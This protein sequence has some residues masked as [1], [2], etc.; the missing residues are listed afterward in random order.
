MKYRV[1]SALVTIACMVLP[2]FALAE[3]GARDLYNRAMAEERVIRD[4]ANKPT[5][6]QMRRVVTLYESVVRKHPA[7]GYCDNA[8][9]QAANVA[10][11]AHQR[12][13]SEADRKTAMR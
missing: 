9:W 10:A 7:S 3:E 11:L 12:F 8:L 5:L 1:L 4:D 6:A 2:S 13:G